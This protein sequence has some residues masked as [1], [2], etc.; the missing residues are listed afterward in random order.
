MFIV[1]VVAYALI[2]QVPA[3]LSWNCLQYKPIATKMKHS[4]QAHTIKRF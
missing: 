3:S 4:C 2:H 1:S